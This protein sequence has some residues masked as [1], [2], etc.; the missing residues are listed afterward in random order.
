MSNFECL[1]PNS[2]PSS[3]ERLIPKDL[4][5]VILPG[6]DSTAPWIVNCC[7]P[8]PVNLLGGCY[9]WCEIPDRRITTNS[10]TGKKD[11]DMGQCLR[12]EGRPLNASSILGTRFASGASEV[13]A[14]A[15]SVWGLMLVAVGMQLL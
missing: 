8:N 13:G 7:D 10:N 15:L 6:N 4:N 3:A 14:K 12:M 1:G 5:H 9:L 11:S 2:L